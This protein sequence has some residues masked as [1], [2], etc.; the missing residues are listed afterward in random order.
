MSSLLDMISGSWDENSK[1]GVQGFISGKTGEVSTESKETE[2]YISQISNSNWNI[3][4]E[5]NEINSNLGNSFISES[6]ESGGKITDMISGGSGEEED[7]P[8]TTKSAGAMSKMMKGMKGGAAK[9]GLAA[10]AI[11]SIA[12]IFQNF[13]SIGTTFTSLLTILGTGFQPMINDINIV[14]IKL[15]PYMIAGSKGISDF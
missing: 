1:S 8:E 4:E 11:T 2:D 10:F 9:L 13:S 14:L 7:D 5:L 12:A 6:T 3:L 15:M